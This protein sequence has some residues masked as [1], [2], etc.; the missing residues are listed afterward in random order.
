MSRMWFFF[1][2]QT[3]NT[4]ISVWL[5]LNIEGFIGLSLCFHSST[6]ENHMYKGKYNKYEIGVSFSKYQNDALVAIPD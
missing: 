5:T 2:W 4:E 1:S 6:Y 3:S